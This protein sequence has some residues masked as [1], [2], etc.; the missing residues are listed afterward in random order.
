MNKSAKSLLLD[1][2]DAILDTY[3]NERHSALRM[4]K[5]AELHASELRLIRHRAKGKL[6]LSEARRLRLHLERGI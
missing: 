1:K 3:E 5:A 6:T 4:M 2:I